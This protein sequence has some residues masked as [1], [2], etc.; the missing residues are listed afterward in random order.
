[1]TER[2]S[3]VTNDVDTISQSLNM[4]IYMSDGDIKETGT[5]E[6]LMEKE[7]LYAELYNSQFSM[8]G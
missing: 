4:I 8:A 6:E 3:R 7:G 1:M 2:L 5:H